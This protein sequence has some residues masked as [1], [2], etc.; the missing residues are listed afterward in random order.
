[1]RSKVI[2]R[3]SGVTQIP[4]IRG[5]SFR[6]KIPACPATFAETKSVAALFVRASCIVRFYCTV[7]SP[8]GW[9]EHTASA[10]RK[11][12]ARERDRA[13]KCARDSRND[14]RCYEFWVKRLWRIAD[15]V[16][17]FYRRWNLYR[18]W[19]DLVIWVLWLK[20]KGKG[21]KNKLLD[22]HPMNSRYNSRFM[23][24]ASYIKTVNLNWE[25]DF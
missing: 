2:S 20:K 22:V 9:T 3:I 15:S 13:R 12:A 16:R 24:T 23:Q 17:V 11:F 4:K 7:L 1:M 18:L 21:R 14:Q 10:V 6:R 8:I 19:H 5:N 25:V